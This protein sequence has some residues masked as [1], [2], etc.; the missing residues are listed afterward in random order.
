MYLRSHAELMGGFRYPGFSS[1]MHTFQ[2]IGLLEIER[3][4]ILNDWFSLA[5]RALASKFALRLADDDLASFHSALSD[6]V[7]LPRHKLAELSYALAWLGIGPA[8]VNPFTNT[9][10]EAPTIP[11]PSKPMAP[12]D[13]FTLILAHKL[14]YQR[15]ERDMVVLSHEITVSRSSHNSPSVSSTPGVAVEGDETHTSTMIAFG[16][17]TAS[18]MSRTVG[19]PVALATL[20]VLDGH[21]R[22]RGVQGPTME[23]V[24]GPVLR[25]LEE[26]GLGMK[27]NVKDGGGSRRVLRDELWSTLGRETGGLR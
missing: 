5:P 9:R 4:L 1:L 15:N 14:R 21:V 27:E 10:K 19:L 8:Q 20:T 13:L 17:P 3:R 25:G 7:D 26:N 23:D 18:A 22:A 24:Y 11:L 2:R 6:I 12:I 16:T